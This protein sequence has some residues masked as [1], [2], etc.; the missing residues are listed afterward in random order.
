AAGRKPAA[1]RKAAGRRPARSTAQGQSMSVSDAAL[2]IVR[3][4]GSGIAAN[5]V[6][7]TLAREYGL[8]VRPNHLGIALQRHRRG[9]RL[10][11]RDSLWY[12]PAGQQ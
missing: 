3:T 2:R 10:E 8:A 11:Q 12:P 5:D 9:G 4:H 1:G 6:L 7:S